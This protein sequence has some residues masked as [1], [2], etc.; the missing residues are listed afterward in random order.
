MEEGGRFKCIKEGE[1]EG[2]RDRE[3][4]SLFFFLSFKVYVLKTST[5]K[6]INCKGEIA[7]NNKLEKQTNKQKKQLKSLSVM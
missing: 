1:R 7:N 6:H 2:T 4:F 5:N 3:L